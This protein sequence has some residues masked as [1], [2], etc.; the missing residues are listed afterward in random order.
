MTEP[1]EP[2]VRETDAFTFRMERDPLLR[3]TIVS[4]VVFDRAPG[5]DALTERVERATRLAPTF[6]ERLM[7]SPFGLVPPR[8]TV[9]PDFDLRWHVRRVAAPAPHTLDTVV[10]LARVAAMTAFDPV[11]PMW[12]FTLV[13]GLADGRAALIM[14]VH[15]ALTD[16]I[17]GIELAEHVLD[18]QREPADLGPMPP[19]PIATGHGAVEQARDVAAYAAGRWLTGA[20]RL[21]ADLPRGVGA[22]VRHPAGTATAVLATAASIARFVRPITRTLSPIMTERRMRTELRTFDMALD[23]LKRA[24]REAGGT[25]ND[26]FVAAIAGGLRRY[27]ERHGAAVVGLRVTMPISLRRPGDAA[28]GNRITLVRF[29]VPVYVA[30]P[31]KRMKAV[32]R[33]CTQMRAEPALAYSSSV[34]GALNLLPVAVSGSM[35]KHVDLLASNVPGLALPVYL[36]GAQIE[37]FYAFGPTIGAAA[38]ITLMSYRDACY[39][40]VTSD[41]GAVPD[42]DAFLECLVE[43]FA[44]IVAVGRARAAGRTRSH[45]H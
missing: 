15:H 19:A 36:G 8:W 42:P 25:M 40:G 38:N 16:G 32:G 23:D 1:V 43:G 6:R 2:H 17:G 28:G 3:S 31:V 20:R 37:R 27:H 11:R 14:K 33:L 30:D 21:V 44:E 5:W 35:L 34:A 9:D 41:G 4:V 22:A 29:E 18:L 26:A 45:Q 7:P 12:E 10:E 39:V 24:G 13:E